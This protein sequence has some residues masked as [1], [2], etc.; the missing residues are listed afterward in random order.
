MKNN[1]SLPWV[2][3]CIPVFNGDKYLRDT[4]CDVVDQDYTNLKVIIG[5]NAS[6][7]TTAE[8]CKEFSE[9]YSYFTY[10]RHPT[11]LGGSANLQSIFDKVDTEYVA[12]LSDNNRIKPTYITKCIERLQS[13]PKAVVAYS[14]MEYI[15]VKGE[16]I[17]IQYSGN[18]N[19]DMKGMSVAERVNTVVNQ[20]GWYFFYCVARL[21]LFTKA[22]LPVMND[23]TRIHGGDVL[24]NLLTVLEGE[25]ER[26]DEVLYYYRKKY[27][28]EAERFKKAYGKEYELRFPNAEMTLNLVHLL[29]ES[30]KL[31]DAEK[32][33]ILKDTFSSL[34]NSAKWNRKFGEQNL[35]DYI[36]PSA[37]S[38]EKSALFEKLPYNPSDLFLKERR[39]PLNSERSRVAII[40]FNHRH[41]EVIPST[42]YQLDKLGY[43]VDV[44]MKDEETYNNKIWECF[45]SLKCDIHIIEDEGN[46]YDKFI[47]WIKAFKLIEFE[48][49]IINSNEPEFIIDFVRNLPGRHYSIL[50]N[51]SIMMQHQKWKD[52]YADPLHKPLFLH[53]MVTSKLPQFQHA[54]CLPPFLP[55]EKCNKTVKKDETIRFVIQGN[56]EP[57]RNYPLLLEVIA[58]LY[59]FR[60]ELPKYEFH[61]IGNTTNE[62]GSE[63]RRII[64]D[65]PWSETVF[66]SEGELN[67]PDFYGKISDC[68]YILPLLDRREKA[69]TPYFEDKLTSSVSVAF[70]LCIPPIIHEDLAE[71]YNISG[72][73]YNDDDDSLLNAVVYALQLSLEDRI[74]IS[75][76]IQEDRQDILEHTCAMA[77]NY[78]EVQKKDQLAYYQQDAV[79]RIKNGD[80][81][82]ARIWAE[83]LRELLPDTDAIPFEIF[84]TIA[85]IENNMEEAVTNYI[86]VYERKSSQDVA[87]DIAQL[88]QEMKDPRLEEWKRFLTNAPDV[89]NS[90]DW[91]VRF[92]R[93]VTQGMNEIH[94]WVG[95]EFY[96]AVQK[97]HI[98]QSERNIV[99]DIVEIGVHHGKFA[100]LL[101]QVRREKE[102]F[103][104]YDLFE[105]QILNI[106]HSGSGSK[107][108]F[109]Q[110]VKEWSSNASTMKAISADSLSLSVEKLASETTDGFRLFSIDGGH[111]VEHTINDLIL[112][113]CTIAP[114]GVIFLDDY[115]NLDW[116]GVHEGFVKY[117]HN[118]NHQIAPF[119]YFQNKLMLC[120]ISYHQMYLTLFR[121]LWKKENNRVKEVNMCGFR[122]LAISNL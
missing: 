109:E 41:D 101:D 112:A 102:C 55:V 54:L 48:F 56:I 2:T 21:D 50:H 90:K 25:I 92:E 70:M 67:Y 68:D 39:L 77:Q 19:P 105:N 13:N 111:T 118:H 8:I 10:F 31:S 14:K 52:Y 11:N 4:L 36:N 44:F 58:K 115:Y 107:Q 106:D 3:V 104:A 85:R 51:P 97:L 103:V 26:V 22:Y 72:I 40:E 45:P 88:L 30:Q 89:T 20:H 1:S 96:K 93:Y 64:S 34:S 57:R 33:E 87:R 32:T 17:P 110:H 76:G 71:I 91:P 18:E 78:F 73:T 47:Y 49:V 100:L 82:T 28:S 108:I 38:E 43:D 121:E 113:S 62:Y 60:D 61:I 80:L 98:I 37:L 81:E 74:K 116:P 5:D 65:Q 42:V 16:R 66:F 75:E 114:G 46:N 12:L 79:K 95:P 86:K 63:I 59:N 6:D 122:A 29:K 120:G 7:D 24:I 99:G 53:Q 35:P 15:D 117:M 84:A 23:Y 9:K 119:A 69:F 27:N 94:G 83:K